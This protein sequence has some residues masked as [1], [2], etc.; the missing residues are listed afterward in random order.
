MRYW[1]IKSIDLSTIFTLQLCKERSTVIRNAIT[2]ERRHYRDARGSVSTI[3]SRRKQCIFMFWEY[4]NHCQSI[5][6]LFSSTVVD[7]WVV[8]ERSFVPIPHPIPIS[9]P[10][11]ALLRCNLHDG[12]RHW[13]GSRIIKLKRLLDLK[14]TK[15]MVHQFDE[16]ILCEHEHIWRSPFFV[17]TDRLLCL[18]P[19]P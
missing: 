2:L 13:K 15:T 19:N 6:I 14:S 1:I 10:N 8:L 7:S 3:M 5:R 16:T 17:L 4:R 12:R 18:I 11:R 9:L